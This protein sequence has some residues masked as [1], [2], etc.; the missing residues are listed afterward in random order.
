MPD[1]LVAVRDATAHG[2]DAVPVD[3]GSRLRSA[4]ASTFTPL[5]L[6]GFWAIVGDD[7]PETGRVAA[8]QGRR[9]PVLAVWANRWAIFCTLTIR[10]ICSISHWLTLRSRAATCIL[11]A[12]AGRQ[13]CRCRKPR[14]FAKP[15]WQYERNSPRSGSPAGLSGYFYRRQPPADRGLRLQAEVECAKGL[16][17]SF[18][19]GPRTRGESVH[20][21]RALVPQR[22]SPRK[23]KGGEHGGA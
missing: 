10:S 15:C 20:A 11:S 16:S 17:G 22:A 1:C 3:G 23:D 5:R 18:R 7:S 9:L 13:A 12:A 19:L 21:V 2:R 14:G 6:A 4:R 8:C